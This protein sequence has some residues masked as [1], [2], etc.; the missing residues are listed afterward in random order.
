MEGDDIPEPE[1][2]VDEVKAGLYSSLD[3]LAG[4]E[5]RVELHQ[6]HGL[7]SSG[8]LQEVTHSHSLSGE[9][10]GS[11]SPSACYNLN[12]NK[13]SYVPILYIKIICDS[14]N[15]IRFCKKAKSYYPWVGS[16]PLTFL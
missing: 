3:L 2:G 5:P 8:P 6:V 11:F 14:A 12:C 15:K 4:G 10:R 9:R 13:V 1:G 7:E 16:N